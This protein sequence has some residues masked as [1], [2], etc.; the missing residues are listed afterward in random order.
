MGVGVSVNK[1][2]ADFARKEILNGLNQL[3]LENQEIFK[4]F[5]GRNHGKRSVEDAKNMSIEDVI[6]EIPDERLSW[7]LS[8]VE[9]TFKKKAEG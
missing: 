7:A 4:L 5:Y 2:M 6:S 3:S 1:T 8:Q 9:N